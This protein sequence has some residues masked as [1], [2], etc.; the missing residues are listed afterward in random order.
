MHF[1]SENRLRKKVLR[2]REFHAILQSESESLYFQLEP[3][4]LFGI[5][6]IVL[7]EV[8]YKNKSRI[9]QTYAFE[10]KLSNW[11]RAL[12]Q[13][14]RY[15]SFANRSFVILD[16]SHI[17]P[18]INNIEQFRRSGIG[19]MSIDKAGELK[20]YYFPKYRRPFSEQLGEKYRQMV[21]QTIS[22]PSALQIIH[23]TISKVSNYG[24][25]PILIP[26]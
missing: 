13:A 5:P 1:Q 12:I 20:S 16:Y 4:G 26:L 2:N 3:K 25:K 14:Y 10:L 19:L 6:D 15:R 21:A 24:S 23:R 8:S 18:A 9:N 7:I 22:S 17:A 11:K